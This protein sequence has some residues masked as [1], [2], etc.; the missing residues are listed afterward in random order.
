MIGP[1]WVIFTVMGA[2]GIRRALAAIDPAARSHAGH[3][4]AAG[5]RGIGALLG[6]LHFGA[7]GGPQ[8]SPAAARNYVRLSR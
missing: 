3:E 8:R 2:A 5:G 1:S 7:L 4:H 6:P